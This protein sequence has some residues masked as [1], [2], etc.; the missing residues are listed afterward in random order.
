[1]TARVVCAGFVFGAVVHMAGSATF[2]FSNTN[3]I[4]VADSASAL[5]KATPYPSANIVT[6][7][8]AQ[9]V[10]KVTVTLQG[11]THTFPSDV[12]ILLVGPRGQSAIL[13]SETGGQ[14]KY[15]VTNLTLTLDDN[16][17]NSLPVFT[18][19]TSGVFKPTDGYLSL[20]YPNL[21]YD[22]PSPAP[23]GKF[24]RHSRVVGV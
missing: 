6:G 20:G 23:P 5:T 4:T 21:P 11:F 2:T 22:F 18:S 14:D 3:L 24:K 12:S 13:M 7:L 19:L 10:T 15:S 9:V 16:A 1:M 17:T 8:D